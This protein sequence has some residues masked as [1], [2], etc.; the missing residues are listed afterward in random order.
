MLKLEHLSIGYSGKVIASDLT[1]VL[2]T[3]SVTALVGNNGCG[4]STLLRT[5]AGLQQSLGGNIAPSPNATT[6][7]IV[8]TDRI[9][10]PAL[11][12]K[13]IVALGRLPHTGLTGRLTDEDYAMCQKSLEICGI[14]HLATRR[15]GAISDGERQKTM[16]A[17][18]IAQDTP[19]ILLDE[20]TAF[21][22]FPAKVET[23]QLLCRLAHDE[24][25][26]I[27]LSTH[28]LE[29]TF[30]LVDRLWLMSHGRITEGTP[31]ELAANGSIATLFPHLEF[32]EETM[33]FRL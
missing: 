26:T 28:D 17:R 27:L 19:I 30:Q 10:V 5:I 22:D 32:E 21:L 4:K 3:G 6:M 1:A 8:L 20:P 2:P 7:S 16:I 31:T 11:C 29:I 12:V 9:D 25:K 14:S 13:D 24:G 23:M 18:A 15:I 33:R